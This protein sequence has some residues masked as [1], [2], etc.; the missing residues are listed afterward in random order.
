MI[1]LS[2][3]SSGHLIPQY[4]ENM[5]W[6][7]H[8][9]FICGMFRDFGKHAAFDK[10]AVG[11]LGLALPFG[12]AVWLSS[13]FRSHG[14]E[15]VKINTSHTIAADNLRNEAVY[16]HEGFGFPSRGESEEMV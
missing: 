3:I 14:G 12:S 5:G 10:T 16:P 11:V 6:I 8:N 1:P 15:Y 7:S 13:H 2:A 4:R 9:Y